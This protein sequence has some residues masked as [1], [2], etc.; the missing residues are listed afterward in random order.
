MEGQLAKMC[1]MYSIG[2]FGAIIYIIVY[3][4]KNLAKA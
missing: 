2:L 1:K 3:E 4:N